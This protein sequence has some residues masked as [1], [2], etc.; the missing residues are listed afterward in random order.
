MP[1]GHYAGRA[2]FSLFTC[3]GIIDRSHCKKNTT[4]IIAD[5]DL[6]LIMTFPPFLIFIC[7]LIGHKHHENFV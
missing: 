6:D 3:G 5:N 7:Q 4:T 1:L 2:S